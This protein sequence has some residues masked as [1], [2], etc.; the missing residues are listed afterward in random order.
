MVLD[1]PVAT[2]GY[3]DG[4]RRLVDMASGRD[5]RIDQA[6]AQRIARAAYKGP[7][8]AVRMEA[9]RRNSTEYRGALPAWRVAFEDDDATHIY[10]DPN[11]GRIAAVRTGTWRLYDFFW[12]LHIMDWK[13]HKD[14]NTPWLMG[15]ARPRPYP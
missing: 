15:F 3:A 10:I 11:T 2:I 8:V 13:N 1:R 12:G 6:L 4:R 14:F 5:L 7:D 9:V